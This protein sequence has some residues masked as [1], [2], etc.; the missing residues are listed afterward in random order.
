MKINPA[1]QQ[2]R[3]HFGISEQARGQIQR[4]TAPATQRAGFLPP[5]Q[6]NVGM[7]QMAL[8]GG[9][10]GT[11]VG[12]DTA[13]WP[14]F[15]Q[16]VVA[17]DPNACG[18]TTL[19]MILAHYGLIPNELGAAQGV[20]DAVRRWGGFSAPDDLEK[21]AKGMG[22]HSEG[23]N[24]NS[25]AD[26]EGHLAAGRTV[27]AMVD[28]GGNPHWITPLSVTTDP[29]G[30]KFVNYADPADGQIHTVTQQEFEGM[31][32]RPNEGLGGFANDAFGYENFLQVF[33]T[34]PVPPSNDFGIAYSQ[35]IGDGISDIANGGVDI[36][37]VFTRGEVGGLFSGTFGIV[38]GLV[39]GVA[40]LPGAVGRIIEM[41]G[42][43][44]LDWADKKWNQGGFGNKVLGALGYVG[45]GIAKGVG[46]AVKTVGNVVAKVGQAVGDGIKWVGEK[47]GEGV[48]KAGEAIVDGVKKVGKAIADGFKKVFSGW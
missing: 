40:G 27:M 38:G 5:V 47:I 34:K 18:T 7:A 25:F 24:K 1:F 43:K 20:D 31:W 39:K 11:T 3:N 9:A 41:G 12:H 28:G 19:S 2:F 29:S 36:G 14:T 30:Q 48:Q 44:A 22:L 33:D 17:G 15:D 42:D 10:G 6:N 13:G 21:Y 23:Y 37:R 16:D 45:G 26:L 32:A 35:A 46:V 8:T 4:G